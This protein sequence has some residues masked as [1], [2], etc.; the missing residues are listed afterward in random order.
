MS[1]PLPAVE[2]S[3]NG[4]PDSARRALVPPHIAWPLF[5][6]LLLL[7]SVGAAAVTFWAAKSDGGAQVVEGSEYAPDR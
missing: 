5:I 2:L 1:D 4:R 7:M 6:V 3:E